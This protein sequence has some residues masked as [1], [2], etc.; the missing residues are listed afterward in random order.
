[1]MQN[2]NESAFNNYG[3]VAEVPFRVFE[4]LM[5][6]TSQDAEKFMESSKI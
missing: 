3:Q 5:N 6:N 4:Y 2:G 1:M